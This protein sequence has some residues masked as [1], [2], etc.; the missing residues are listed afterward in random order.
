MNVLKTLIL[1]EKPSVAR[2]FARALNI[3]LNGKGLFEGERYVVTWAIGH[4]LSP[5]NP[6]EYDAKWK[7]WSLANLPIIPTKMEYRPSS[8]TKSQLNIIKKV[9]SRKDIGEV[10]VATD[11]GREGELIARTILGYSKVK[12]PGKRFW[13]SEALSNDVIIRNLEKARPLAQYDRLFIAGKARQFADWLVGMNLSRL[14]T[15]K[16][17]DLYSIGRVQTAVL[18]MLV[19]RRN[20][21]DQFI[22]R[23]Y[24]NVKATMDVEES[25]IELTWFDLLK[26]DDS[27]VID[28]REHANNILADIAGKDGVIKS[29]REKEKIDKSPS[30]FSLT[31]LQ[32]E[33]NKRFKFSAS[34]TLKVAQSLYEKYKC[35]SYPRTDSQFMATSSVDLVQKCFQSLKGSY[36]HFVKSIDQKNINQT[37]KSIFNDSKLTDHHALLPLKPYN[38]NNTDEKKIFD[39]VVE[40]FSMALSNDH[41]YLEQSLRVRIGENSFKGKGKTVIQMGWKELLHNFET[42]TLPTVSKDQVYPVSSRE[43]VEKKTLPP[44]EYTEASLL[45]DMVNPARLVES[46]EHKNLFRGQVGLGTQATRAQIIETLIKRDYIERK[47]NQL[48][49]LKKGLHLVTQLRNHKILDALTYPSQT[50]QWEIDLESISQG[51]GNGL[52]FVNKIKKFVVDSITDWK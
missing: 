49:A 3:S 13:T 52:D 41:R 48:I 22:S 27:T 36:P 8:K 18:A 14:A 6:D 24:W 17:G 50:A 43:I 11:A 28:S 29:Y 25:H 37:N 23:P 46:K 30:L 34:K 2:D 38:G 35:L 32:R 4:L 12:L 51:E 45:R 9:L 42:N 16:L 33:A 21:I 15:L 44:S 47:K 26:N 10:I 19:D 20:E 7:K 39:L 1:T 5:L 40:R 31:D